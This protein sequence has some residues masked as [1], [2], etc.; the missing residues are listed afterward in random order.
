MQY[1]TKQQTKTVPPWYNMLCEG[2]DV[3]LRTYVVC[4]YITVCLFGTIVTQITQK[5]G[6]TSYEVLFFRPVRGGRGGGGVVW[7]MPNRILGRPRYIR[8]NKCSGLSEERRTP[9]ATS[10]VLDH[11]ST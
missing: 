8:K 11:G 1:T 9:W 6:R 7:L 4:L 2:C 3:M 5:K 10:C